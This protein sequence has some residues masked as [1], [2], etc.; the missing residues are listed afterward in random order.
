MHIY[1]EQCY[2]QDS[3]KLLRWSNTII[4]KEEQ[5]A[6]AEIKRA[7]NRLQKAVLAGSNFLDGWISQNT[8]FNMWKR[9]DYL[10][11]YGMVRKRGMKMMSHAC[12]HVSL[13]FCFKIGPFPSHFMKFRL[14]DKK[15]IFTK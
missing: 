11:I 4:K 3:H 13:M 5:S 12:I 2:T 7:K 9:M 8:E 15:L 6:E 1:N 14:T 10:W